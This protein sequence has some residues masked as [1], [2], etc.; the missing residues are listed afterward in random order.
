MDSQIKEHKV[1]GFFGDISYPLYLCHS[2]IGYLILG[3][4]SSYLPILPRSFIILLPLPF[5]ITVAW[6]IH[7]YVEMPSSRFLPQK[8]VINNYFIK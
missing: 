7:K 2:Y 3:V 5:V 1:F 6:Y 4:V 8:T